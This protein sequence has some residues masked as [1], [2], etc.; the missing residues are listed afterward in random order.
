MKDLYNP[1]VRNEVFG[2]DAPKVSKE[3][4]EFIINDMIQALES[5]E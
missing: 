2:P 4:L 5:H 1:K 3:V